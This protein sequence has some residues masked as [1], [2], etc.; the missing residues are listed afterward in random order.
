[1]PLNPISGAFLIVVQ[2]DMDEDDDDEEDDVSLQSEYDYEGM[3]WSD[4]DDEEDDDDDYSAKPRNFLV[5]VGRY[6]EDIVPRQT[7]DQFREHFRL[8][9]TTFD[10]LEEKLQPYLAKENVM[11]RPE[12]DLRKIM[13]IG[14]WLLS[15]HES[16]RYT[17]FPVVMMLELT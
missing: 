16:H 17:F 6:A 15:N 8:S 13:L 12:I 10:K 4:T 7:I 14:I 5:K 3:L 11:G 2:K 9:R 1:M